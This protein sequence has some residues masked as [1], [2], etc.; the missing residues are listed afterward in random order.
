MVKAVE[1]WSKCMAASGYHYSEGDAIDADL[2]K[3]M[4]KIVGP[5]P[6]KFQTG[7]PPGEPAR[8]YDHARS[9]RSSRRRSPS[10]ARTR[11]ASTS[12]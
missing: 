8:P 4:E 12:T 11:T 7:P 3:R 1:K 10:H 9:P 2:L 6:G 5:V